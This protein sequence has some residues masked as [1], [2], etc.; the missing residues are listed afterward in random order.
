MRCAQS[1]L[2]R[3]SRESGSFYFRW[4]RFPIKWEMAAARYSFGLNRRSDAPV[5]LTKSYP[6]NARAPREKGDRGGERWKQV[7]LRLHRSI[8]TIQSQKEHRIIW[9]KN[10]RQWVRSL[11]CICETRRWQCRNIWH[12]WHL[13]V[14][15]PWYQPEQRSYFVKCVKSLCANTY[16]TDYYWVTRATVPSLIW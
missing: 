15:R 10:R 2:T 6:G 5:T 3:F 8:K 12:I 7:Q 16:A 13:I 9:A 4:T 14:N 1:K 11:P